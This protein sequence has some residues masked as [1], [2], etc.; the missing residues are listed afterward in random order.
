MELFK[1]AIDGIGFFMDN[2]SNLKTLAVGIYDIIASNAV[3]SLSFVLGTIA[4]I[5]DKVSHS[6]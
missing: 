1:S 3:L 5:A 2:L 6:R 4:F